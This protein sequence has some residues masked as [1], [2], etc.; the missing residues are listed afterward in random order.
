[1]IESTLIPE[2]DRV[3]GAFLRLGVI[4]D[5]IQNVVVPGTGAKLLVAAQKRL[6][7]SSSRVRRSNNALFSIACLL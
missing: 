6:E 7:Y 1:M 5:D 2:R 3:G 4:S